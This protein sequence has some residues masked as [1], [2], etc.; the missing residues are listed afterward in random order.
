MRFN[1]R[2]RTNG[3]IVRDTFD[4]EIG[5]LLKSPCNACPDRNDFPQCI[6][7][8]KSIDLIQRRLAKGI[9]CTCSE[10]E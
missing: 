5:H 10:P 4:F 8:C 9:S 7:G 3:P 1:K 6:D 2:N